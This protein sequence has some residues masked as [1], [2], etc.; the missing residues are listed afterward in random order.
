MINTNSSSSLSGCRVPAVAASVS[1][2]LFFTACNSPA[3]T[4]RGGDVTSEAS[5][6]NLEHSRPTFGW[7][8]SDSVDLM[9]PDGTFIRA[10]VE[11]YDR[12]VM[13]GSME[14]GYP[15]FADAMDS[16]RWPDWGISPGTAYETIGSKY[17]KVI[18]MKA[19]SES[20]VEVRYCRVS[21]LVGWEIRPESGENDG[22]PRFGIGSGD[23]GGISY[24]LVYERGVNSEGAA[25]SPP[26]DQFGPSQEPVTNVFGS[27]TISQ[28]DLPEAPPNIQELHDACKVYPPDFPPEMMV[29]GERFYSDDP[30][31]SRPPDP[32]WPGT[33]S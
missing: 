6:E 9:S 25:I 26:A 20:T 22:S 33:P 24:L 11:S 4:E 12:A 21:N 32:G 23:E 3:G 13:A 16:A 19:T 28:I 18:E 27:W 15:G 17:F 14:A 10:A 30:P 5:L 2:A 1:F 29:P 7:M 31:V 8:D